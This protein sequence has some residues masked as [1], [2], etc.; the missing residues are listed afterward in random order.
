MERI[1]TSELAS[2]A[3]KR[4]LLQGWLH[5]RRDLAR[6]SFLVLRDRAGLAQMNG[7]AAQIQTHLGVVT[8][9][10]GALSDQT[11]P[12]LD[13]DGARLQALQVQQALAGLSQGIANQAPQALLSLFRAG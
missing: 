9:L 13:A 6:V 4:V 2:H 7:Q 11:T 3:G 10:S 5:R 1:L 8:Q 12:D